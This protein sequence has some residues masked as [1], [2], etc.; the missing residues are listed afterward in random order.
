MAIRRGPIPADSFTIISNAWLR[1]SALSWKAK[2]LLAYI[3]SHAPGHTLTS[4]QI[5]SEGTDGKDA[6][7]AGLVELERRGYL[8]RIQRRGEGGKITGTDYELVE[9]DGGFTGA[10]KPVPGADQQEQPVS[11]GGDQGGLSGAGKPASKKTTSQKTEKTP[12]A[13][14]RGA[15][16]PKDWVPSK[17]LREW[18]AETFGGG[19][20]TAALA[21]QCRAEH[22]RFADHWAAAP[23]SKGVKLDWEATWRNWMR[24]AFEPRAVRPV[25]SP[26]APKPFVQQADLYKI[27]RKAVDKQKNALIQELIDGGTPVTQAFK[28]GEDFKD[29][30]LTRLASMPMETNATE[31]YIEGVILAE[32]RPKEVTGS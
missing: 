8:R 13:S 30:A 32:D 14:P 15:R 26:P 18:F 28:A 2:G 25:S 9:P 31:A 10:G 29:Q 24:R 27:A 17:A 5:L 1:D 7:R 11:A 23:G 21:D 16:L 19:Q 12:S 4:E 6:V 3:A 22:E 20:W